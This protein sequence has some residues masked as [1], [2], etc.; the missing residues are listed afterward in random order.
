MKTI[1]AAI[2]LVL[3]AGFGALNIWK[4]SKG[5]EPASEK[6]DKVRDELN[7]IVEKLEKLA[8]TTAPEWDDTLADILSTAI[9]AIAN[10]IIERLEV[11]A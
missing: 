7:K 6:V 5:D 4:V 3:A 9:E 10:T 11:Q 8:L 1:I 2:N